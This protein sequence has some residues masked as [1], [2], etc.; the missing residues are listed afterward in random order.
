MRSSARK[1][2][3]RERRGAAA[4]ELAMVSPL[5]L[6]LIMGTLEAA[7]IGRATQLLSAA[8]REGAR[9]AVIDGKSQADVQARV[10]Q[11]LSG[12]GLSVGTVSPSPTTW[13]SAAA[14]TAV[15][16]TLTVPYSQVSW[17]GDPFGVDQANLRASVTMSS[18]RER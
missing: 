6:M 13:Q 12:S 16:V 17:V 7:A 9:V 5:F 3:W 14:G 15:T 8:A 11:V 10:D 2:R 18:E 4:V 1:G